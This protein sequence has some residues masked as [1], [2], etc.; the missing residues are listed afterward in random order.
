MCSCSRLYGIWK[1][2]R[3]SILWPWS[4]SKVL[5]CDGGMLTRCFSFFFCPKTSKRPWGPNLSLVGSKWVPRPSPGSGLPCRHVPHGTKVWQ[6]LTWGFFFSPGLSGLD[7]AVF[8]KKRAA[9]L[10]AM[11][12]GP[13]LAIDGLRFGDRWIW[14][15]GTWFTMILVVYD[16]VDDYFGRLRPNFLSKRTF[17]DW[18]RPRAMFFS[19][20][21]TLGDVFAWLQP[22]AMFFTWLRP[23]ATFFTWLQ[24]RATF[25]G[26]KTDHGSWLWVPKRL[27]CLA[28]PAHVL[29]ENLEHGVSF[30]LACTCFGLESWAWAL[31]NV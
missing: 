21:G 19:L 10:V 4:S 9:L 22:R 5:K 29:V 24:P 6:P 20:C 13:D 8:G 17:F 7:M 30:G 18:I 28:C 3:S 11:V 16:L 31:K 14:L 2:V 25:F 12:L 26:Q 1:L 15:V 27:K 23:W